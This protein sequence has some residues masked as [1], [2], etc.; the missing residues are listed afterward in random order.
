MVWKSI[1]PK[2]L[3]RLPIRRQHRHIRK[4]SGAPLSGKDT[5]GHRNGGHSKGGHSESGR[6]AKS[7]NENTRNGGFGIRLHADPP[8]VLSTPYTPVGVALASQ[9][10]TPLVSD[11][12]SCSLQQLKLSC[13][14]RTVRA[15]SHIQTL[16]LADWPPSRRTPLQANMNIR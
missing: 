13:A 15:E 3:L 8:F 5:G 2:E 10:C 1:V 6:I 11:V 7:T 14:L 12:Y 16:K 4:P 9:Q